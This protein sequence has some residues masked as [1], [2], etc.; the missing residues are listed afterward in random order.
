MAKKKKLPDFDKMTDEEEGEWFKTHDLTRY[1][2]ETDII[3]LDI[4]P[5]GKGVLQLRLSN[6]VIRKLERLA[7]ENG[8]RGKSTLAGMVLTNYVDKAA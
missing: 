7:R 1:I 6:R 5:P 4:D 8:L 3:H 2:D